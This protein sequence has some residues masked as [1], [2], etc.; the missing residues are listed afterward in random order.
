MLSNKE[1]KEILEDVNNPDIRRSFKEAAK[2][3]LEWIKKHHELR[4]IDN[5]ITFLNSVQEVFGPFPISKEVPTLPYDF[6]L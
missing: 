5:Y 3:E 4:S 6:R 1:K 2:K